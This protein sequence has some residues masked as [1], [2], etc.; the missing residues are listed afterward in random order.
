MGGGQGGMG[1]QSGQQGFVGRDNSDMANVFRQM[2]RSSNQFF[3]Q[4]NRTMGRG[5]R[6][7][8]N[9]SQE[10]NAALAVR[11]RLDVVDQPRMQPTIAANNVRTRL[12]STLSSRS[13]VAP[14][15]ELA[16]DTVIL[17]GVAKSESQRLVI[18]QLAKMEPGVFAVDNQMTVA[19]PSDTPPSAPAPRK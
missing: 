16:G 19:S 2:G 17:R 7:R 1:M 12:A 5:G 18:E 10:E 13:I 6:G 15:V 14:E 9:S 3:Q 8:R 11:V 4:L